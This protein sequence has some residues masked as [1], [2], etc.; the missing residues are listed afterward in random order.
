VDAATRRRRIAGAALAAAV[1]LAPGWRA[2]LVP[3]D[4]E[5]ILAAAS[6][7]RSQ[8]GVALPGDLAGEAWHVQYLD[9]YWVRVLDEVGLRGSASSLVPPDYAAH[10]PPGT[11]RAD[12]YF[13][14]L[15]EWHWPWWR[16][17]GGVEWRVPG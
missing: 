7:S 9:S 17:G 14:V 10:I 3:E 15:G 16:P 13:R 1:A 12:G 8:I 2:A 11:D 5:A 4:H 6:R